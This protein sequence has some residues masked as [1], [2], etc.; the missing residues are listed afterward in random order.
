MLREVYGRRL[1]FRGVYLHS[2]AF[3]MMMFHH[4][5]TSLQHVYVI[6]DWTYSIVAGAGLLTLHHGPHGK[7]YKLEK[8]DSSHLD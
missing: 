2:F 8:C 4:C 6:G 1:P 7:K 5:G 3:R